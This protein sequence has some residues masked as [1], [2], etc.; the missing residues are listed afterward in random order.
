[1][2]DILADTDHVSDALYLAA[3]STALSAAELAFRD[4][5]VFHRDVLN[6][7][8]SQALGNQQDDVD[9]YIAAFNEVGL[10]PISALVR[11]G[12]N[13]MIEVAPEFPDTEIETLTGAYIAATYSLAYVS[14]GCQEDGEFPIAPAGDQIERMALRYARRRREAFDAVIAAEP[15]YR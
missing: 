2:S 15:R 6:G 14:A 5:L 12:L 9:Q 7:G 8:L 10:A 3:L 11:L 13:L 4:V 1:M